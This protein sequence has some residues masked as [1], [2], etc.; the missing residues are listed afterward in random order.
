MVLRE[1]IKNLLYCDKKVTI[2]LAPIPATPLPAAVTWSQRQQTHA[3]FVFFVLGDMIT[4]PVHISTI[5][6]ITLKNVG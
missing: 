5:L 6:I 3:G 4:Q 1:L 2:K